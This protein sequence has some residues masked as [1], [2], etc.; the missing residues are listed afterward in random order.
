MENISII[1]AERASTQQMVENGLGSHDVLY[2]L[3]EGVP[4][5][6]RG[7]YIPPLPDVITIFQEPIEKLS[8]TISELETQVKVTVLHEVAH[9]FGFSDTELNKMGLG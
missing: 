9:Y 5:I 2:G 8:S 3:Y 7:S 4:L 1:V 6:E